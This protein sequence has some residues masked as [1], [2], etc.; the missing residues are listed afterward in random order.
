MIKKAGFKIL[1]SIVCKP[2]TGKF[3]GSTFID[4]FARMKK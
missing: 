2:R 3:K 4:V 1:K